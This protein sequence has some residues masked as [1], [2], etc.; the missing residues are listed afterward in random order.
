MYFTNKVKIFVI[1]LEYWL[2]LDGIHD[3]YH[4]Q[5]EGQLIPIIVETNCH[6]PAEGPKPL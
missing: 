1:I 5:E 6:H 2:G 4:V 3:L